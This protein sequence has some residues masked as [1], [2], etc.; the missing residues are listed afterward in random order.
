MARLLS[1]GYLSVLD[2]LV[3]KNSRKRLTKEKVKMASES[4]GTWHVSRDT[5]RYEYILVRHAIRYHT[6]VSQAKFKF[7][8]MLILKVQHD[9]RWDKAQHMKRYVINT[10]YWWTST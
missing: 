4:G 8:S 2:T 5:T 10:L 9:K 3:L 7:L 1:S 6:H